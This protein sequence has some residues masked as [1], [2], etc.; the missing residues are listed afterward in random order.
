[1]SQP[2][3]IDIL[4]E[5]LTAV[6][7]YDNPLNPLYEALGRERPLTL[8][9]IRRHTE[10]LHAHADL[11]RDQTFAVNKVIVSCKQIPPIPL[12]AIPLGF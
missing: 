6:P 11:A 5:T 3:A 4:V 2:S 1:M 12:S 10:L 8:H 7:E 9:A